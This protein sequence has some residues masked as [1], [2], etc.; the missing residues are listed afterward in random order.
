MSVVLQGRLTQQSLFQNALG[1]L[2]QQILFWMGNRHQPRF[3]R[4][5]EMMM[6]A[7]GAHQIPAIRN[8]MTYQISAIHITSLWCVLVVTITTE[9]K[10]STLYL[11]AVDGRR[12]GRR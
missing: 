12:F 6:T 7:S 9:N 10:L 11:P 3:C 5:L 1:G 8:D 2:V 4:V